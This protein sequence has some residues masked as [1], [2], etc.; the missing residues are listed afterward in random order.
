MIIT[1][2]PF[3]VSFFGGGS[4]LPDFYVKR[5]GAVL[6]SSIDKF[7]YI[8]SHRSFDGETLQVK[9]SQTETVRTAGELRHPI[10]REVLKKLNF[11]SGL[12]ITSIA[13]IPA[14]TGLGSSS[15]FCVALL[16]NL[17]VRS[18]KHVTKEQL[19]EEACE[20]EIERLNEPIG[21][22]DQYAAAF[23]GLNVIR[24]RPSGSV[25][26]EPI[27]LKTEVFRRL[28]ESII[29]LFTGQQRSAGDIL[30][31]QKKNLESERN[32]K[33]LEEMVGLVWR[34]RAALHDADL[35][36]FGALLDEGWKLKRELADGISNPQIDEWYAV[37][38]RH[39]AL[40]GKL[41]GAGGGGFLLLVCEPERRAHILEGLR[42]LR[43]LSIGFETEGSKVI[44]VGDER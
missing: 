42:N 44:Y 4:D 35:T 5:E 43:P 29:L 11:Q 31:R 32:M 16:H 6:S 34:G 26:V 33:L 21:K 38:R 39:G 8:A 28:S 9:Y 20:V 22:Q 10:V 14:G 18:G 23:G 15:S 25:L 27:H 36:A 24:F 1:R 17:H 37:A 41:L 30:A 3:R 40:G 7:M 19:A 2:S 13:D 12:E